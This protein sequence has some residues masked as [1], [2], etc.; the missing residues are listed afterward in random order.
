MCARGHLTVHQPTLTEWCSLWLETFATNLKPNIR[1]N[2][3]NVVDR[4]IR[5]APIGKRRLDKLT[6]ADVQA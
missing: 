2:Y 3:R 1:E 5:N 4:Y 6:P